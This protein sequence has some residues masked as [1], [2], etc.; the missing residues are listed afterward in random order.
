MALPTQPVT[1]TVEQVAELSQK[2]ST[3]R[4]DINNNL[5]LIMASAELAR[6]RPESAHKTLEALL[7]QPQKISAIM[8]S[9]ST[10]IEQALGITRSKGIS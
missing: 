1:L 8:N 2:L 5:L 4:H 9:F 6:I 3:L 7:D 10:E